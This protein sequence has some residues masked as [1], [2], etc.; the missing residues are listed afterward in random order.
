MSTITLQSVDDYVAAQ[1]IPTPLSGTAGYGPELA[2]SLFNDVNGDLISQRFN[3][4]WNRKIAP[5]FYTNSWQ[6]DYPQLGNTDVG[7]LEEFDMVQINSTQI[8]L[9]LWGS[10]DTSVYRQLSRTRNSAWRPNG[11]CWMYNKDLSYGPW[12]GPSVILNPLVTTQPIQQNP[13]LSYIDGVGNLLIIQTFGTTGTTMPSAPASSVE[14]TILVDGTAEWVVVAPLSIGFRLSAIPG[15]TQPVFQVTVYYQMNPVTFASTSFT[16]VTLDPI[17]DDQ[18]RYFRRGYE[19]YCLKASP[20]PG[21]RARFPAAQQQWL[22]DMDSMKKDSAHEQDA[23]S[24]I[25]A[26]WPIDYSWSNNRNP[27]DPSQ[28]F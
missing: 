26:N 5:A 11:L 20:N 10:P 8:P 6:Q 24:M 7:W 17:P 16:Q 23:Y 25:P 1:G 12:P 3:W 27:N 15:S 18:A 22:A 4:K 14:G 28:P 19:A 21:D 9:P 13:I 2:L